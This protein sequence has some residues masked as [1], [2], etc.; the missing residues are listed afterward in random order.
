MILTCPSPQPS[1]RKTVVALTHLYSGERE[2]VSRA[3]RLACRE[4]LPLPADDLPIAKIDLRGEG[5]GEGRTKN[6]A[7]RPSPQPSPRKA[8][9]ALTRLYSGERELLSRAE[10]LG[11][12]GEGKSRN[13]LRNRRAQTPLIATGA[14]HVHTRI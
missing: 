11:S 13:A 2:L 6:A 7:D 5:G 9:V 12:V 14:D 1:P 3:E 8:F 4:R 10:R